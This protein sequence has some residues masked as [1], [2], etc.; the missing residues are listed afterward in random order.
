MMNTRIALRAARS[1]RAPVRYNAR[2]FASTN[3]QAAA[4][5]GSSGLVGGLA[6]GAIVFGLGY[7]Y[8]HFS[9][10]KSI[11]NAASSTKNQFSKLTQNIQDSAPEPNEAL[12]WLRSTATSYAAFIPGAKS[13]VDSAFNDLDK[14][15]ANHGK[16]VEDIVNNA[17][18][19]L[20]QATKS[21]MSVET[22]SKTWEILEKT[23]KQLGEL[24]SDSASE[25][26]DNHPQLK[27]KVGGNLDQLKS[28]ADNYGP[29]A[30]KQ[31]DDTYQQITDVVKGGV[32]M[33]SINKVRQLIQEKTE[34][35]KKFGDEAWKKG[36]EQAKPYL[37]KNPQVKDIIEKNQDTLKN[38]NFGELFEQVKDAVSSGNTDQL[39]QYVKQA[40]EKYSK[41]APNS[42]GIMDTLAKLQDVAKD[43]GKEAEEIVKGA[44]EDIRKVLQKRISEAEKV[45]AKAGKD[46]K[47]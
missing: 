21:G 8:Y 12:K 25:I 28:M 37:D 14:V 6:G 30:K 34:Q 23:I 1:A 3:Q 44:Y 22:A 46:A 13:Y 42:G 38:G 27:E 36:M 35:M 24:A 26:L 41:M 15:Q 5:G 47:Q 9:G 19:E 7:S 11:V 43:H 39:Q 20:K 32:S 18:K 16:E 17:Y 33:E 29:E 2:R 10:A 31:L 40:G 45:A 4:A